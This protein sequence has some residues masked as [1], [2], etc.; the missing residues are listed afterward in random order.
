MTNN[1]NQIKAQQQARRQQEDTA[2]NRILL[3]FGGAVVAEFILLMIS[4]FAPHSELLRALTVAVPA[5]AV[6]AVI[7]YLFQH[8][9]FCISAITACGILCLHLYRNM[10]YTHRLRLFAGFVLA[11]LLLAAAVVVL[12]LLQKEKL[13]LPAALDKAI[14]ILIPKEANFAL[15]YVTCALVAVLLALTLVLGGTIAYYLMFVLAGWLF[16]MAVYYIVKLM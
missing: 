16:I 5:V 12:I 14:R 11:F 6:L 8:D 1:V 7:Y 13:K 3:W 2:L 9:F 4:R 10:L 15:L